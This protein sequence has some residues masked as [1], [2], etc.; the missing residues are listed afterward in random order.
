[1]WRRGAAVTAK[2]SIEA[3]GWGKQYLTDGASDTGDAAPPEQDPENRTRL[4]ARYLRREFEVR[5]QVSRA[6]VS[7]CGLGFFDLFLNG[8]KVGD[9]M[10][11]PALSG[12]EKRVF[13]VTFDVTGNLTSGSNAVG[14]ILGNGRYFAPRKVSPGNVR[15]LGRPKLMFQMRIEY[16]DGTVSDVISDENWKVT[17]DGPTRANNEFDG[18]EYDARMEMP[19]WNRIGFDDSKWHPAE[20][21]SPPGG[22]L[23]SQ[24]IEPMRVVE[25][26]KPV[27]ITNP[28]PGMYLVD[29][30][31]AYYGTVRLKIS[32]PTASACAN[33]F[34]L[35]HQPGWHTSI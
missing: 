15:I 13:Y 10:M 6:T 1:M 28:K 35:Q 16:D 9:H 18:E 3:N 11:D 32:G 29:M 20:P 19:A 4:S 26:R 17:A 21:V 33:A 23:K 22:V 30:G 34:R 27:E 2:D 31:Q 12:Y 25:V 24:M 8:Q 7:V 14:V 5:Q